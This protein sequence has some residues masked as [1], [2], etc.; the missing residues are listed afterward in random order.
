MNRLA[1]LVIG[2][3]FAFIAGCEKNDNGDDEQQATN[4]QQTTQQPAE[5]GGNNEDH[6]GNVKVSLIEPANGATFTLNSIA[7]LIWN[8]ENTTNY[9]VEVMLDKGSDPFDGYS[10]YPRD[11][12]NNTTSYSL[13]LDRGWFGDSTRQGIQWGVRVWSGG[14]NYDSGIRVIKLVP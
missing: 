10:E 7:V 3:L 9:S 1:T 12:G 11:A 6:H 4:E 5:P 13:F 8:V 14:K 2:F